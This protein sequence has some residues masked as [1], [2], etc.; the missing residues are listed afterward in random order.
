MPR[1]KKKYNNGGV[2]PKRDD[3]L[4]QGE[5]KSYFGYGADLLRA[6]SQPLNYAREIGEGNYLPN[7]AELEAKGISPMESVIA[8]ANP[9]DHIYAALAGAGVINDPNY[10]S[11]GDAKQGSPVLAGLLAGSAANKLSRAVPDQK[12]LDEY[13]ESGRYMLDQ[14]KGTKAGSKIKT[15]VADEAITV[16]HGT[17]A[18]DLTADKIKLFED[19]PT[20]GARPGKAKSRAARMESPLENVGGFYTARGNQGKWFGTDTQPHQIGLEIPKGSKYIDLSETGFYTDVMSTGDLQK[21]YQDGY[22]YIIGKNITGFEE[23]IPLNP[24][25][26]QSFRYNYDQGGKFKV[27]KKA[28]Q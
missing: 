8:L 12:L 11:D 7:Q 1:V 14:L 20:L 23:I 10:K 22:D 6:L 5:E 18:G 9:A 15:G 26:L 3:K 25:I 28:V 13:V 21:M 16:K 27:K 24:E 17:H 2:T 19:V 4:K